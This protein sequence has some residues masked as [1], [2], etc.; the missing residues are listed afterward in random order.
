MESKHAAS[1]RAA[2]DL[3]RAILSDA[4]ETLSLATTNA[5]NETLDALP[6]DIQAGRLVRPLKPAG[7]EG[8]A[9]ML[10]GGTVKLRPAAAQKKDRGGVRKEIQNLTASLQKARGAERLAIAAQTR[11][12]KALQTA[13]RVRERAMKAL[14]DATDQL[15]AATRDLDARERVA[16][17]AAAAR[18]A[19]ETQLALRKG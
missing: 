18:D 2:F 17:T 7:F 1:R 10:K 13:K 3:I 19:L 15:G 4:G 11:A 8:L 16:V 12:Q 5:I 9:G 6:A 14:D